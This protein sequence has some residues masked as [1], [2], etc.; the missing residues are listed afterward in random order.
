[1]LTAVLKRLE[2]RFDA[3]EADQLNERIAALES[4]VSA[5]ESAKS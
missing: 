5:L 1:M 4:R 2:E 3:F